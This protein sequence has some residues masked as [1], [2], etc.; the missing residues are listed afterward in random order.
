MNKKKELTEKEKVTQFFTD[1]GFS[2]KILDEVTSSRHKD[3][4]EIILEK[5]GKSISIRGCANGIGCHECDPYGMIDPV[6][7]IYIKN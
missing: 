3:I 6:L 4:E 2:V 1:F 7:S 5:D